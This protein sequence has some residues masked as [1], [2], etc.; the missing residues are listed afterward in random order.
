MSQQLTQ[1]PKSERTQTAKRAAASPVITLRLFEE[2]GTREVPLDDLAAMAADDACFVWVDLSGFRAE[3]LQMV[4]AELKLPAEIVK[5]ALAER[6]RPKVKLFKGG[7]YVSVAV[8][9]GNHGTQRMLLDELDLF[10]GRNY[11]VSAH[12]HALPYATRA[13]ERADLNPAMLKLDSAFLLYILV[14]ELLANYEDLCEGLEE[15]IEAI[16]ERALI[17][18]SEAFLTDLLALKQYVFAVNRVAG[19]HRAVIEGFLRP[20][21]PLPGGDK[22]IAYFRDLDEHLGHLLDRLESTKESVNGA[23]DLYVSQ[24]SRRTNDIMKVL[25]IVSTVLLPTSVILSF[26]GTSLLPTTIETQ[27][28]FMTMIALIVIVTIGVLMLFRHWGWIG[29]TAA[30]ARAEAM[31]DGMRRADRQS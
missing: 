28:G 13:L 22:I 12:R 8:P 30:K 11:L 2:T 3:D 20:D 18:D 24:V 21:F 10:V 19:Q 17:D 15:Q 26:F 4:A 25:A 1:L 5:V 23:F 9:R 6:R 27:T 7:C 16:E 29:V 14:D 31:A